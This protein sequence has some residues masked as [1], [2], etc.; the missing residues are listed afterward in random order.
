MSTNKSK[1]NESINL[2]DFFRVF[3]KNLKIF[4]FLMALSAITS[5]VAVSINLSTF[6]NRINVDS[7]ISIK[8]PIEN[9]RFID[10]VTLEKVQVGKDNISLISIKDRIA[11]Y[12][13]V[14][15]EYRQVVLNDLKNLVAQNFL[16]L[17]GQYY[18][19]EYS[20]GKHDEIKI[21]MIDV[22]DTEKA[23]LEA[24]EF[25]DKINIFIRELL[26]TN[27][28][29]EVDSFQKIAEDNIANFNDQQKINLNQRKLNIDLIKESIDNEDIKNLK[30]FR[31]DVNVS[32]KVFH[33][34]S[35]ITLIFLFF[36][37]IFLMIVVIRK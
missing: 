17:S 25:T 2:V 21:K 13:T 23:I 6:T 29:Y 32:E 30:V 37:T 20:I 9:F 7:T 1:N 22:N 24:K 18:K 4:Y 19:L 10:L 11:I 15:G 33:N 26:L 36:I 34:R 28:R 3:K 12:Y 16:N 27:L 31:I 35:I 5:I 14:T 8:S